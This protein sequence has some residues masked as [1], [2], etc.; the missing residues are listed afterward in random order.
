MNEFQTL[1]YKEPVCIVLPARQGKDRREHLFLPL[2]QVLSKNIGRIPQHDIKSPVPAG[3]RVFGLLA[4]DGQAEDSGKSLVP[5]EKLGLPYAVGNV[6]RQQCRSRSKQA[7]T[8]P[9]MQIADR[10]RHTRPGSLQPQV[11]PAQF[12]RHRIEVHAV[13]TPAHNIMQGNTIRFRPWHL[14]SVSHGSQAFRNSTGYSYK[15]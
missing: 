6:S 1:L 11:D 12:Y 8:A 9:D 3:L 2:G 10:Q 5:V 14:S 15:K 13:Y 7:I 4:I